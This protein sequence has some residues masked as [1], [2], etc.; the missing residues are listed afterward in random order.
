M[1][2]P[3]ALLRVGVVVLLVGAAVFGWFD[4]RRRARTD[5]GTSAHRTD[6]TVYTAAAHAL[7]TGG[8]PYD[9]RSPRGWRYVYPPLLAI[10]L[11]PLDA[12]ATPDAALVWYALSVAAL[13][14]SA[15][16]TA[17]LIGRPAG[18]A[19]VAFALTACILFV[20]QTLQR[21]QVTTLLLAT[22]VGALAL[23]VARREGLA[24]IWL[25]LGVALRLT[26]LLPAGVVGIACVGRLLRGEGWRAMRFPA[27][28]VAGLAIWFV[29]V[30]A[31]ALGPAR[32]S[33]VTRRWLEVG[34]EVYAAEPGKLADLSGE[35]GIEEFTF[36]NQGVRRVA[37]TWAGWVSGES[38]EGERSTGPLEGVDRFALVVVGAVG[39]AALWLGWRRFREPGA[40]ATRMLYAVACLAPVWVTRY[41]WPVHYVVAVPFVAEA[42]AAPKGSRRRLAA[43]IFLAGVVLFALG[44]LGR[45]DALRLPARAGVLALASLVAAVLALREPTPRSPATAPG[46]AA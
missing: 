2:A 35:Y 22:Q 8:D 38:F 40:P 18:P 46:G 32:A 12:L 20:G 3:P 24:G 33:E 14:C 34:R 45:G 36:K 16:W 1:V 43:W 37:S 27:G 25:A 6:F 10:A 30:P 7:S 4:V 29:A 13:A 42:F 11:M 26:P 44:Y 39:A 9:A 15:V 31:L 5:R 19:S 21:G 28:F 17:R 41:A 23:L